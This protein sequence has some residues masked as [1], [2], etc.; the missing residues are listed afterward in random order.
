MKRFIAVGRLHRA[1]LAAGTLAALLAAGSA[2]AASQ[3]F[4]RA[5]LDSIPTASQAVLGDHY[6]TVRVPFPG[7][8]VGYPNLTYASIPGY[9]PLHLDLYVP[10]GPRVPHPLIVY[11]HG[12]GWAF[13]QPRQS[14][15]FSNWPDVLA[16]IASRGYVVASVAY[17]LSSEAPFPAAIQD[18]KASIRWLRANAG[19]YGIDA[20]RVGVWGGSAGGHL[21]ALDAVTCAV[22]ALSPSTSGGPVAGPGIGEANIAP[23]GAQGDCVQAFATWYGVFDFSQPV[24]SERR[25]A[26]SGSMVD[27]FLGC[28]R[29]ACTQQ[30]RAVASPATYVKAGEPPALLIVGG[31]DTVVGP[32]QSRDFYHLLRSKGDEAQLVIIPGVNHSF[33][34]KTPAATRAASLQALQ[35]TFEF[36][37]ATLGRGS[38]G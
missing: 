32:Q 38:G 21:A 11:I 10:P 2:C 35:R 23:A 18:V 31:A 6:P 12:G 34:G 27:R 3:G 19:E 28:P 8:V 15:A 30:Q 25:A 17:R 22:A 37:E 16:L 20:R 13:G 24:P 26:K 5:V 4:S 1:G 33:V 7:G 14:G 9:Q 36:F 29:T